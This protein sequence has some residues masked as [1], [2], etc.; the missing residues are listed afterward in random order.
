MSRSV[1]MHGDGYD[2][3]VIGAGLVGGAVAYGLAR[4]GQRVAVLDEED[5][6]YRAS[7]GNFGLVWVQGKGVGRPEYA[8]WSRA[9]SERWF[10]LSEALTENGGLAPNYTRPGGVIAA[11][12]EEELSALDSMLAGLKRAVGNAGYEYEILDAARVRELLPACGPEVVG[13]AYSPYDGHANPLKLMRGLHASLAG[14]G[15][16][17]LAGARVDAIRPLD[18]GGFDLRTERGTITGGK[19]VI[20]AGHGSKALGAMVGLD[21]PVHPE[22]GQIVVT[23]RTAP[24]LGHPTLGIRQTDEGSMLFGASHEDRGFDTSVLAR[25]S[26]DIAR[27]A[28]RVFPDLASLRVVR[29]WGA[30]RVMT[31]DGFPIY[32]QSRA[33]PGAFVFTCHSGVTLAANHA[34]EASRWVIDGEIPEGMACFAPDRFDVPQAA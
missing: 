6:T 32:A 21:V 34:L 20:A 7:R 13:G 4:A 12:S 2:V 26:R 30:L 33:H 27:R 22:H 3:V 23:E 19:V 10:E 9:S 29:T 17:Y 14:L 11:L 15:A 16:D 1:A 28:V 31:P 24:W 5:A 8:L 18:G 25:T